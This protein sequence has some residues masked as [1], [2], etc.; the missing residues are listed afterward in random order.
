M[1]ENKTESELTKELGYCR[2][3]DCGLLKYKWTKQ[4]T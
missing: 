4:N 3:W 2:V 1:D